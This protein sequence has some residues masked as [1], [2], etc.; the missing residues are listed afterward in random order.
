MQGEHDVWLWS[1]SFTEI[2][3]G[4]MREPQSE[5]MERW[6]WCN[7]R[8]RLE[9]WRRQ[10]DA[11]RG[12]YREGHV[13]ALRVLYN[14]WRNIADEVREQGG[15]ARESYHQFPFLGERLSPAK[16]P[17]GSVEGQRAECRHG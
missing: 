10:V 2:V 1:E 14:F 11:A 12:L 7:R 3:E 8:W 15:F 17:T 13:D 5:A 9:M 6:S 16:K 4:L